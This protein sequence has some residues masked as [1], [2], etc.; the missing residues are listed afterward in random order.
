MVFLCGLIAIVVTVTGARKL[1]IRSIPSSLQHAIGGGIGIFIA[2]IGLKSANLLS[3]NASNVDELTGN[4]AGADVVPSL[5]VFSS[6]PI[7]FAVI[8]LVIMVV[9]VVKKVP[10]AIL[11]GIA[12]ST[13][14]GL[15]TGIT[16]FPAGGN[17]FAGLSTSFQEFSGVFGKALTVGLPSL[18]KDPAK[19]PLVL[20][21]IFAFSLTDI[22]DTIG[23]FIGTGRHSGIF[24]EEELKNLGSSKGLKS[25]LERGLC[26]DMIATTV[27]A[28][29]GTS[30]VTTYVESAAGIGAGGRTGLTSL[31]TAGLFLLSAIFAPFVGLVPSQATAPALIIVGVMMLSSFSKIKW[32]DLEEALPA[33]FAGIFMALCYSISYGIAAAFLFYCLVKVLKGKAKQVPVV[34]WIVS[35]LFLLNF[36][37]LALA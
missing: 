17:L 11:I 20:L 34:L 26:A 25:R 9:L 10:G 27:G 21:T 31:T 3:F 22:F 2:Y 6:W 14:L 4:V 19:L 7:V 16:K 28:V 13:V 32:K 8:S 1:L 24:S 30:N 33:F 5:S 15:C 37:L 35:G 12:A 36:V 29:I 23:T 18:F